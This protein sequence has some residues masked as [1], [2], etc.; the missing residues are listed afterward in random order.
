MSRYTKIPR[1]AVKLRPNTQRDSKVHLSH[2]LCEQEWLAEHPEPVSSDEYTGLAQAIRTAKANKK[3]VIFFLAGHVIKHG[4]SAF[5]IN[6]MEEGYITHVACNGSVA[7]HEWELAYSAST[8]EDVGKYITDGRF[9]N[10]ETPSK[11]ND[12]VY[13]NFDGQKTIGEMLGRQMHEDMVAQEFSIIRKGYDL[14][15]PVTFH[16]LVGGDI[17]HQHP[18]ADGSYF[19]ASYEDFLVLGGSMMNLEGG[20]FVN[21]GSQVTGTEV[22]LKALSMTR[23]IAT[24]RGTSPNTNITTAMAD[25]VK[26]PDDWRT[27]EASEG[28]AAYYYR[29]WKTILLRTVADGG[30]SFYLGGAHDYTVPNLWKAIVHAESGVPTI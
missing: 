5:I 9:G 27:G 22:F 4:L 23:N 30:Q 11:M 21:I 10:W 17:N 2:Q 7:I 3:P 29:P 14:G 15:I 26:L 20:V 24:Q 28:D 13:Q 19:A 18:N 6:L 8:S 16:V 25:F 1:S 12:V